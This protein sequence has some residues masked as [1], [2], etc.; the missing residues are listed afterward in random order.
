[1]QDKQQ[2]NSKDFI[3]F[4]QYIRSHNLKVNE[5]YLLELLFEYHNIEYGYSFPKFSD[6]MQAFNTTSKN[7]I[8]STIKKLEKKGLIKVDRTFANNR[9]YVIGIENFI[10]TNKP[11]SKDFNGKPTIDGQVHI[12][13][14]EELT[15][16]EAKIIELSNM[17]Y[18]QAKS[19]LQLSKNKANKVLKY[20]E[21]ALKRGISNVY[22]YVKKLIKVDANVDTCATNASQYKKP[23]TFVTSCEGRNYSDEWYEETEKRLLGWT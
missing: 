20:V 15:E 14:L 1:M 6:I 11:K 17:S 18:K 21:Y 16:N 4:R 19:L 3:K 22:A 2:N 12:E 5:Q 23:L 7:R 10:N 13:E 8:S 9:Y